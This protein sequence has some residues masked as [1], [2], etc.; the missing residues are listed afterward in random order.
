L[1]AIT[2]AFGFAVAQPLYETLRRNPAF[3]VAHQA[4]RRDVLVLCAVL[5]LALPL[6]LTALVAVARAVHP[7]LGAVIERAIV[8]LCG[9]ALAL[10]VA[11][12]LAL[13]SWLSFAF[14]LAAAAVAG[15]LAAR[16][17]GRTGWALLGAA[18]LLFPIV[19]LASPEI[20]ALAE[21]AALTADPNTDSTEPKQLLERPVVVVILDELPLAS[22]LTPEL[23]I[24]AGRFPNFAQLAATASWYPNATSVSQATIYSVPA[25]LSGNYP[26]RLERKAPT[27]GDYP[28]N[29]FTML[30]AGTAYN[31]WETVTGL[32]PRKRCR[33]PEGWLIPRRQRLPSMLTDLTAVY[34]QTVVPAAW[35]GDLPVTEDRWRDFWQQGDS[36]GPAE[37]GGL[38]DRR[39]R[40]TDLFAWF[41]NG[42]ER[43]GAS[44]AL[45]YV[46]VMLPHRPWI[47]LPS[48][49]RFD[50]FGSEPHG[51]VRQAWRGTEWETTQAHQRHLLTVGFVDRL[52]GE[53]IAKL[54]RHE[55][56]DET[57]IVVASDHG[58]TFE[59]GKRRRNLSLEPAA[60]IVSIP[61]IVKYPHQETGVIDRRNAEGV[62]V[63][64]T[65]LAALDLRSR[66]AL[67]R[68]FDGR[69]LAA[70][71]S[72]K[73]SRKLTSRSGNRKA[74]AGIA[75]DY[76]IEEIVGQQ[77]A[78]ERLADRFGNGDW[79]QLFA[80]GP[81]PDLLDRSTTEL[82]LLPTTA[83]SEPATATVRGLKA[84]SNVD[85]Q[86]ELLPIH[87]DAGLTPPAT[88]KS[89]D[90][91]LPVLALA[92]N[93]RIRSTTEA[94][95]TADDTLRFS[96]L[97]P[98]SALQEG[99][100][101]L[102]IYTV[103]GEGTA[104]RFRQLTLIPATEST[105]KTGQ[106]TK[107]TRKAKR[108]GKAR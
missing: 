13:G 67:L 105:K 29:L 46:H 103:T 15:W 49:Q 87:L 9:A 45:H 33:R 41:L 38:K 80:A 93:G 20:S 3:L 63:L 2:G 69:D 81:R 70:P 53:L 60:E 51:M 83:T 95:A 22:L 52:L 36:A 21:P 79:E 98:P 64:P 27:V 7:T 68:K 26:A 14:A 89:A 74:N 59:T 35:S 76:G 6:A 8:G 54:E 28:R 58:S 18:A 96:T 44:P 25:M 43:L 97:L 94:Y 65:I 91:P 61:L 107:A 99:S 39:K 48:G 92:L 62:D 12:R 108:A 82:E 88:W 17:R 100:N 30:P 75:L 78:I 50:G 57:L 101:T 102:E 77:E 5:S 55:M 56:F 71:A 72:N 19:L 4:D 73:S 66:K 90:Q 47:W 32:C 40:P 85:P 106:R 104:T 11:H 42:I 37:L 23:V 84:L 24:D 34:L 86:A 16:P 10:A 31:V 1:A